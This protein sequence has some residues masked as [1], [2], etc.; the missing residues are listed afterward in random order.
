MKSQQKSPEPD[1]NVAVCE[2]GSVA[3][4]EDPAAIATIQSAATFSDQP[5]KYVFKTEGTGGQVTYRVIQVSDGQ[6]EGQTDG[7]AAVSLVTGFPAAGQT[8]TQAVFSQTDGLEGDGGAEAQYAY[9]PATIAEATSGTMVTT[10]QASDTL[11]GQTTPTGQVYVMMS[12]QEVLTGSSQRS[13]APRTQPYIA[14][15]EAPRGSRDEKRRA[16]HNEVERRR[17]DKIN[18]WIVQLS[19]TIPDCNIDYTKTGQSKGGI[20]SKACEYIKELRQSNLKLGEDV[21]ALDRV[22]IDNQLL[23]QEIED[24]KSKNQILRNLLRQH[25]IVGSSSTEPQ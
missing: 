4:A 10:V 6:L 11:L 21:G 15:Q 5:I 19:K 2:E 22:R 9:Y 13:I 17:R 7:A 12:P 20:L 18:N 24:W 23:R 16:Q 14:K 1:G 8:V 25:G 3:T